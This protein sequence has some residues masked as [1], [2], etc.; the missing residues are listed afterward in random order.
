M[1]E[2]AAGIGYSETVF[3]T[4]L[5]E[6]WRVRYFAP[7]IEIPFCGHATIALGA[8]LAERQ[9]DGVFR[10]RLNNAEIT[11]EGRAG[12]DGLSATLHSP[13]TR[14]EAAEP[15]LLNRALALFGWTSADLDPR[16]PPAVIE[17]GARHLA[18]T[19]RDRGRLAAMSYDFENGRTLMRAHRLATISLIQAE[20]HTLFHAR[21]P[22]AAGGVYED[23]ATGAAAAA[24]AGY[25]RDLAWP[26]GGA[27]EIIQGEDMGVPCRLYAE[28]TAE[29]AA[30]VRVSG[31]VRHIEASGLTRS[32]PGRGGGAPEA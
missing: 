13:P 4:P 2:I 21:N 18:L 10:L 12:K 11:V 26:H 1:Q 9:D 27:I 8:A 14:S 5:N 31:A 25:L 29:A 15:K 17:A 22:F 30:G 7:Q 28:I 24:W 6:G 16:C 20:T 19:L 23:P 32:S 3:A